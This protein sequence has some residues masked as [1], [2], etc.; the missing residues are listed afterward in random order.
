MNEHSDSSTADPWMARTKPRMISYPGR[1]KHGVGSTWH[2]F[3]PAF[4]RSI[5]ESME[6]S[7]DAARVLDALYKKP[8]SQLQPPVLTRGSKVEASTLTKPNVRN[9]GSV[10]CRE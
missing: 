7:A 2:V 6:Y 4:D 10:L 1:V 9:L 8:P 3:N 5:G